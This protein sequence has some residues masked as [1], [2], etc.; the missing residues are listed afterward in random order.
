MPGMPLGKAKAPSTLIGQQNGAISPDL[1]GPVDSNTAP[2]RLMERSLVAPAMA[3]LH[4]EA[5]RQGFILTTT[6]R[7]RPLQSQWD[8]FGGVSKRY[9]P[10]TK[11]E[12]DQ[13][14]A[15]DKAA[16][17][18]STV[19]TWP[20]AERNK[21]IALLGPQKYPVPDATYWR[22]IRNANGS[23]PYNSAVP[24]TSN[25]GDG[26]SDDVAQLVNGKVVTLQPDCRDWAY[27]TFPLYGFIW[28]SPADPPHVSWYLGDE[29][30][31]ALT[32]MMELIKVPGDRLVLLRD[33]L[34]VTW[35]QDANVLQ[36]AINLKWVNPTVKLIQ[37]RDLSVLFGRGV[38]PTYQPS[39]QEPNVTKKSDF[40]GWEV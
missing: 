38:F 24:G 28:E 35:V 36:D 26:L 6:G 4:E 1:L 33:G 29:V 13:R 12:W 30:P 21:V 18:P 5:R 25:H 7:Y 23:W 20:T 3:A 40:A 11:A 2:S 17:R 14:S 22:K 34:Y 8:I 19:K 10:C 37:R 27:E 32:D 15:E 39:A 9:E 31:L 16:G